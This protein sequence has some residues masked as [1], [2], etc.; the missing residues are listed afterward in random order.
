MTDDFLRG[1]ISW[2]HPGIQLETIGPRHGGEVVAIEFT[3][4]MLPRTYLA[5]RHPVG[6]ADPAQGFFARTVQED[7]KQF[8][9]VTLH[10]LL[11]LPELL[12]VFRFGIA[13]GRDQQRHAMFGG[14]IK[15]RIPDVMDQLPESGRAELE[16]RA[17]QVD[18]A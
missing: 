18:G 7:R 17:R 13:E 11:D 1:H 8:C 15:G 6:I 9:A 10:D 5:P 3:D 16:D 12:P 4:Q 14:G 2:L